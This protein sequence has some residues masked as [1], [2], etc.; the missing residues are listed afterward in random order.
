MIYAKG[1]GVFDDA[2]RG[3]AYRQWRRRQ[4]LPYEKGYQFGIS[5][6]PY[7]LY[8]DV[9]YEQKPRKLKAVW[10]IEPQQDLEVIHGIR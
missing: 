5:L 4:G 6:E 7:Q 1:Y 8:T 2:Y 3:Q 10:T 9:G